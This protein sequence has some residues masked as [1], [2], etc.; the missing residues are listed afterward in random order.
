MDKDAKKVYN[1]MQDILK[2]LPEGQKVVE[3]YNRFAL[4]WL[5]RV[6]FDESVTSTFD[7]KEIEKNPGPG[8]YQSLRLMI[9]ASLAG[10]GN[11]KMNLDDLAKDG[12]FKGVV[13]T[14]RERNFFDTF[15]GEKMR[16]PFEFLG[17]WIASIFIDVLQ[18]PVRAFDVRIVSQMS[19]PKL[20]GK[21]K[22]GD[23]ISDDNRVEELRILEIGAVATDLDGICEFV[24]DVAIREL[25]KYIEEHWTKKNLT[26]PHVTAIVDSMRHLREMIAPHQ[27]K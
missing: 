8:L 11:K 25:Q 18:V 19:V 7:T 1:L 3:T 21:A 5:A 23:F 27:A 10:T 6:K 22:M 20:W 9:G 15:D 26:K 2:K 4:Q 16:M 13:A 24:P 14:V 12:W 17:G